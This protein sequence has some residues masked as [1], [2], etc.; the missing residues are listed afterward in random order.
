MAANVILDAL[1]KREDFAKTAGDEQSS[2]QINSLSVQNLSADGMI[3]GML[4]KPD[5]Q[6][7]TN[8]WTPKQLLSFLE[9]FLDD[10]LIPSVI[11]W[12]SA[13]HV[14]VID[15]GHRLSALRAWIE[16][17]YG[18]R[19]ISRRFFG[20]DLSDDQ[21]KTAVRT[22]NLVDQHI[23]TYAQL[24]KALTD[25]E[26]FDDLV[27]RRARKMATRQLTLQW[28]SG[29]SQKAESSF[30]KINTQGTPLHKTEEL[31]LRNRSRSVAIAARSIARAA[32]GHKYWSKFSSENVDQI[33]DLSKK[34]HKVLFN[35]EFS[36]PIR[37]LD[38]P[39]GGTKSPI[40]AL[41]VLMELMSYST[42]NND[43]VRTAISG[44]PEDEDGSQTIS[45][46]KQFN[47]VIGWVSGNDHQS[48]GL[49][50]AIYFYSEQGRHLPDLLV[51]LV[52]LFAK[53]LHANHKDFFRIF[54]DVRPQLEQ[55]LIKNK[56]L[57]TQALQSVR[58]T[59]RYVRVADFLDQLIL[60]L[61]RG[62]KPSEAA[63]AR[64]ITQG[65][66]SKVL[67]LH[68]TKTGADFKN[69][70]KS[71]AFIRQ[72]IKSATKCTI[73]GGYLDPQ[74]SMSYDHVKRKSDGGKGDVDNCDLTHHYCNT[75][76]KS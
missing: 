33:E 57:I 73:C 16:D 48:L 39:L 15:G 41:N 20:N 26:G 38:L 11:L 50:P 27:V 44:F 64:M 13:A 37:T 19:S 35:P 68:R 55:T 31:L 10:E 65:E 56:F 1:I 54:T 14:F 17:D 60:A 63:I 69:E 32:A 52:H 2:E 24:R 28:V 29:D 49:H 67:A 25:P 43:G 72:T 18:D 23:G 9:S 46:L 62:E 70:T 61:K 59:T 30:F 5:F 71:A 12:R 22:R 53:K 42:L 76:Y 8:Q 34:A 6:R 75:G 74:K 47:R 21:V 7:E 51:G 66:T 40:V 58:S 3:A 45:L 36:Q 4:R